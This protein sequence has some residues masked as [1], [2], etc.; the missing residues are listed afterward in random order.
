MPFEVRI[1]KKLNSL[2][3]KKFFKFSKVILRRFSLKVRKN[4][5]HG[6]LNE[7]SVY[8]FDA[9][10]EELL[11]LRFKLKILFYLHFI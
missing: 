3:K 8:D 11:L 10:I 1:S 5:N 9:L 2:K 7:F 4:F 6:N